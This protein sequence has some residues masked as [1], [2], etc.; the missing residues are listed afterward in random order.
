MPD[1][2]LDLGELEDFL[3]AFNKAPA[4]VVPLLVK[5]M[6]QSLALLHDDLAA[7]PPDSEAN[8][9]GRMSLRARRPM[10]YYERG[11]GWWYPVRSRQRL[12]Q[13]GKRAGVARASARIA[14]GLQISGYKLRRTSER[15]GTRWTQKVTVQEGVI[16]G[17][18]GNTASYW[19]F[20][21][22]ERQAHIHSARGWETAAEILEQDTPEILEFFG[23][24]RDELAEKLM[25][26]G[27]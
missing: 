7:Y 5:A 18:L 8:R 13:A 26:G 12:G 21:Q 27:E 4:L 19:R 25:T 6:E 14:Q 11:K 9:P 20:V 22:G 10:G 1:N 3:D 23:Q 24:A 16:E 2:V 17:E 15:L